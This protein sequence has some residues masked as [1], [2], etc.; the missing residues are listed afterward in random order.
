MLASKPPP[1]SSVKIGVQIIFAR[2]ATSGNC[3]KMEI[4]NG[5]EHMLAAKVSAKALRTN[6]GHFGN[7]FAI[8][9]SNKLENKIIPMVEPAERAKD[10]DTAV[11]ASMAIRIMIQIPRAFKGAGLRLAKNE[12]R[13]IY[14]IKAARSADIGT[15][16]QIKYD[17]I[18]ML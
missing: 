1:Q 6:S 13:A 3:L 5:C 15:A 9:Y 7:G 4:D 17:N 10:T 12:N 16:A 18:K 2:G 14:A 11:V 8:Q